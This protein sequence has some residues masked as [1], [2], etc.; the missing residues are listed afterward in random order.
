MYVISVF[1]IHVHVQVSGIS[2]DAEYVG[3]WALGLLEFERAI[4]N[5]TDTFN[6]LLDELSSLVNVRARH[7]V[8]CHS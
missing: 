6:M 1:F 8:H 5:E 7:N 2:V 4:N 3:P